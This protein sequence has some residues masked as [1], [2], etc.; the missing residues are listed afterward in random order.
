[1][2]IVVNYCPTLYVICSVLITCSLTF[3]GGEVASWHQVWSRGF[4]QCQSMKSCHFIIIILFLHCLNIW[5]FIFERV[6]ED[7]IQSMSVVNPFQ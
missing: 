1:L 3:A 2:Y 6:V 7:S 4:C 5:E